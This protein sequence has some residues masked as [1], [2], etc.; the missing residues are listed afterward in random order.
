MIEICL[1]RS[2]VRVETRVYYAKTIP[3]NPRWHLS[4]PSFVNQWEFPTSIF[5]ILMKCYS[6]VLTT[7][8]ACKDISLDSSRN[9]HWHDAN[10]D[11]CFKH[12]SIRIVNHTYSLR[13]SQINQFWRWHMLQTAT[14]TPS[15]EYLCTS[16]YTYIH[17]LYTG[18]LQAVPN[19]W[20]GV[21]WSN[22]FRF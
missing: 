20:Y 5:P 18:S 8:G 12:S 11:S 9:I 10:I 13:F 2:W 16:R 19:G 4:L 6:R 7:C 15:K 1:L 22:P 14:H 17:Q 3:W 21:P